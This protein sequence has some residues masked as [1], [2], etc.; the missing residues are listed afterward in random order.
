MDMLILAGDDQQ[1]LY[2][3]LGASPD[4]MLDP[5]LPEDHIIVL[6][7]SYRVPQSVLSWSENIIS[8]VKRRQKKEYKP[9]EEDGKVV[10]GKVRLSQANAKDHIDVTLRSR[11]DMNRG[12]KIMVLASCAICSFL[13]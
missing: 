2:S 10:E 4:S 3:F 13:L 11:K 7:Q 12:K 1:C 8:K 6:G 5:P 9:R